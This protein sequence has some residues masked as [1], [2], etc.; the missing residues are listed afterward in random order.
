LAATDTWRAADLHAAAIHA[1][2][3]WEAQATSPVCFQ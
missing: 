1:F 3:A 2:A